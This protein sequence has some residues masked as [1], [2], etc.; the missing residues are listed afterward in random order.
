MMFSEAGFSPSVR[1]ELDNSDPTQPTYLLR[2]WDGEGLITIGAARLCFRRLR[3]RPCLCS[4]FCP[5][6]YHRPAP[7]SRSALYMRV[8]VAAVFHQPGFGA[9][10]LDCAMCM[11]RRFARRRTRLKAR[12]PPL[13]QLVPL[14]V[15]WINLL[16]VWLVSC[17]LGAPHRIGVGKRTKQLPLAIRACT[18][19][20][21]H[22]MQCGTHLFHSNL[23]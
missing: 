10:R 14:M 22:E 3:S 9:R 23:F 13:R 8:L 2:R 17:R 11:R 21:I 5:N 12:Q 16:F 15:S 20:L 19:A 18:S 6:S 1:S 4:C 7:C